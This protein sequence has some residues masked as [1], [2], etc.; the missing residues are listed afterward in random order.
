[1]SNSKRWLSEG[2]P[3]A[4]QVQQRFVAVA[5]DLK[6]S[7]DVL[8][9][10]KA[11]MDAEDA[12][13]AA[14]QYGAILIHRDPSVSDVP[15]FEKLCSFSEEENTRYGQ[16][17]DRLRRMIDSELLE[18][19]SDESDRL[20]DVLIG[21]LRELQSQRV[22]PGDQD[23]MD[24]RRRKIRSAL[25][26]FTAALQI[27]EHQTIRSARRT[28][29]LD[30]AQVEAVKA[31][32]ADL[33]ETS[34]EYRWLEALRDALQHGDINAFKWSF[35]VNVR[36]D[37][38]VKINM[39]RAFMLEFIKEN[40]NR[41]WLKRRELEEMGSDPNVLDMIKAIQ[42]LMGPPRESWMRS[43]TPMWLTMWQRCES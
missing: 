26:S 7:M 1:M 36:A 15:I 17:Y 24:E 20:C 13:A 11:K 3:S 29:G 34:F 19:I 6:E 5:A 2:L 22:S 12:E 28:Q 35:N 32:F 21:V 9:K 37:P 14:D 10:R 16:A 27:H 23:A 8:G 38:E 39:D 30:R 40:R 4:D 43:C 25:I 41:P 42:P 33:K 31:L 18:H